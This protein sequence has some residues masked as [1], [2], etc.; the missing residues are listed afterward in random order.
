VISIR[1][2]FKVSNFEHSRD[3]EGHQ[4]W[5]RCSAIADR[6]RW[7]ACYSFRQKYRTLEPADNDLRTL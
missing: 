7:R 6:P 3:M 5:T 4:N 2:K 1:A